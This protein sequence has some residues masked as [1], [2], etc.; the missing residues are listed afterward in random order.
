MFVA[1]QAGTPAA[2]HPRHRVTAFYMDASSN[3]PGGGNAEPSR[4]GQRPEW[5]LNPMEGGD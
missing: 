5:E 1:L 4:G 2:C 3:G